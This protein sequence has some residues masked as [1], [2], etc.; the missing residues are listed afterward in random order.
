MVATKVKEAIESNPSD[1]EKN[2]CTIEQ[3]EVGG[4]DHPF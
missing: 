3:N 4:I 2:D 1:F